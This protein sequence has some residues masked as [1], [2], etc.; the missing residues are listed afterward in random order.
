[1]SIAHKTQVGYSRIK[2]LFLFSLNSIVPTRDAT[3]CIHVLPAGRLFFE[4]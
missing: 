1:M 3:V 2:F 4:N